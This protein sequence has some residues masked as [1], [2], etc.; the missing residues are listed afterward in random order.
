[1]TTICGV[2]GAK[3][4]QM[5]ADG[6]V[7]QDSRIVSEDYKKL[8]RAEGMVIGAAGDLSEMQ[9]AKTVFPWGKR[10]KMLM[11]TFLTK[12]VVKRLKDAKMEIEMMIL[13]KSGLYIVSSGG[14]VR[15]QDEK[16]GAIGTGA[17]FAMGCFCGSAGFC[18]ESIV[19]ASGL[20]AYTNQVVT[21]EDL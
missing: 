7:V 20:D 10:K 21:V 9:I 18:H 1:M 14:Y 4:K 8:W 13:D 11:E 12:H 6:R 15:V 2:Y 16:M 17:E 19:V 5:A 3:T